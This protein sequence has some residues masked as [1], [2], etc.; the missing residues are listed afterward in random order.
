MLEQEEL[1]GTDTHLIVDE[2]ISNSTDGVGI[3]G[4]DA[5][6]ELCLWNTA[7]IN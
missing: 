1:L 4:I 7:T 2:A 5:G 3:N 6:K